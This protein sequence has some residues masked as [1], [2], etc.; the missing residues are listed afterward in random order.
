M[1]Y[2]QGDKVE[3]WDGDLGRW[4]PGVVDDVHVA[5]EPFG[6]AITIQ[7]DARYQ[8]LPL[9]YLVPESRLGDVRLQIR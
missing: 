5:L 6:E 1:I 9:K 4:V 7:T 8:G 3:V 2:D